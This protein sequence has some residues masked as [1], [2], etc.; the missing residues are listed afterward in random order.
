MRPRG[1]LRPGRLALSRLS[2]HRRLRNRFH[3]RYAAVGVIPAGT[4]VGDETRA[5]TGRGEL[6][7]DTLAAAPAAAHLG[8][9]RAEIVALCGRIEHV[10]AL[11]DGY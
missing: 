4:G 3:G 8:R 2:S 5:P 9:S 6:A 7:V 11:A 10:R 1:C